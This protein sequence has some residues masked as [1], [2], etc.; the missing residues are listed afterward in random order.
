MNCRVCET[1]LKKNK[2]MCHS[3]GAIT[4]GASRKTMDGAN[5][6]GTI[7]LRDVQSDV[8]ERIRCGPWDINF[9][10]KELKDGSIEPLGIALVSL[11]LMGGVPGAGKSTLMSQILD[12]ISAKTGRETLYI[13][14]E[15]SAEQVKDRS[16]RIGLKHLHLMRILP[17]DKQ[18]GPIDL[19][20]LFNTY[21]PAA[22]VLDSISAYAESLDD[23]VKICKILKDM[24]VKYRCPQFVI[25]HVTKEEGF[26]GLMGLQ[27]AVDST[28]M[29]YNENEV[30]VLHS[31]KNR[32]G[33]TGVDSF[34]LMSERG[35]IETTDPD[36][37]ESEEDD[38]E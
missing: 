17:V 8:V 4:T 16:K 6:D 20:Q 26:A 10:N 27:H 23:Q 18:D 14:K 12:A 25:G 28:Q 13:G 11:N 31:E 9:G 7:L 1:P 2:V 29:L 30:R 34:Y 21:K 35:L 5:P 38:D 32:F 15:E 3:C 22:F 36:L 33:K 24:G 19:V 37:V